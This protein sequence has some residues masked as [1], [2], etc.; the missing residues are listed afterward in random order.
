MQHPPAAHDD[1]AGML[2]NRMKTGSNDAGKAAAMRPWLALENWRCQCYAAPHL[3][4][5]SSLSR[6]SAELKSPPMRLGWPWEI[7]G[8]TCRHAGGQTDKINEGVQLPPS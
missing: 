6:M 8:L 1:N 5:T 3:F 4:S 7:W 2:H